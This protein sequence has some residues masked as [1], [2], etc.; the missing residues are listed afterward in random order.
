MELFGDKEFTYLSQSTSFQ[1][2]T[3]ISITFPSTSGDLKPADIF[4]VKFDE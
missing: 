1:T 3:Y 4:L 2:L